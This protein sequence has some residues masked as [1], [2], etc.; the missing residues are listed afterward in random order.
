M[1]VISSSSLIFTLFGRAL[2]L[3]L[4][5]ASLGHLGV[6]HACDD[7][8]SSVAHITQRASLTT[9][10]CP[11]EGLGQDTRSA[12]TNK[13]LDPAPKR[14][15]DFLSSE[16]RSVAAIALLTNCPLPPV[17]VYA[18]RRLPPLASKPDI[19]RV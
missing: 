5:V 14:Y 4:V 16:T 15:V 6:G 13:T 3:A 17:V 1:P 12:V 11:F 9:E 8:R 10:A 18:R 19:L 7:D 2:L